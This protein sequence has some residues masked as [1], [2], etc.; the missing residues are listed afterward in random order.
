[1]TPQEQSRGFKRARYQRQTTTS[2][3]LKVEEK[4]ISAHQCKLST[5]TTNTLDR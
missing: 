1:M 2:N 5:W 3:H 4:F